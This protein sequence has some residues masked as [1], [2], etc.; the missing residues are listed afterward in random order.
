MA[1][2]VVSFSIISEVGV[3]NHL[4]VPSLSSGE[5]RT[6]EIACVTDRLHSSYEPDCS[7]YTKKTA[8]S[9]VLTAIGQTLGSYYEVPQAL[10]REMLAFLMQLD[11][12]NEE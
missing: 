10:P 12:R 4:S 3:R 5:G 8:R 2:H 1:A 7:P 6:A 11:T 9:A